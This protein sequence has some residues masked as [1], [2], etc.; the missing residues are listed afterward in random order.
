[1]I[2]KYKELYEERVAIAEY[3]GGSSI[4]EAEDLAKSEIKN[5]ILTENSIK[6]SRTYTLL[7]KFDNYLTT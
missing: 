4:K 7:A 3:D 5:L 1:M 6:N 2:E